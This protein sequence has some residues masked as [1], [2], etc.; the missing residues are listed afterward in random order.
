MAAH[1]PSVIELIVT[2]KV[3]VVALER[4]EDERLVCLWDLVVREPSLVRQVHVGRQRAHVQ[5][6]RLGVQLE[7]HGLGRL[8]AQDEFIARDVFE[9]TLRDVLELDSH[10]HFGLV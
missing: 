4:V 8:D 6:R 9:N 5:A 1:L 2:H 7:V 3:G 10:F